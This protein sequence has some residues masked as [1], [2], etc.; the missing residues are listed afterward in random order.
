VQLPAWQQATLAAC[1]GCGIATGNSIPTLTTAVITSFANM[2]TL[3][4]MTLENPQINARA[5]AHQ[6]R[7]SPRGSTTP[8]AME[9]VGWRSFGMRRQ[10]PVAEHRG[11]NRGRNFANGN[12]GGGGRLL[13]LLKPL[14]GECRDPLKARL[15]VRAVGTDWAR[16]PRRPFSHGSRLATMLL[17]LAA[18][19]APLRSCRGGEGC[20]EIQNAA[21]P[22]RRQRHAERRENRQSL[23][24]AGHVPQDIQTD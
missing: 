23:C 17:A 20:L 1:C 12:R 14:C 5:C 16:N 21:T 10:R 19:L 8:N 3:Q 11:D 4:V 18:M 7:L 15:Q 6:R 22:R 9:N 2:E 13:N 24:R